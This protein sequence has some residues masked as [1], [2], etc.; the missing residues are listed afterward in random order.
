[1]TL[2]NK[3][4]KIPIKKHFYGDYRIEYDGKYVTLFGK[5][6]NYKSMFGDCYEEMVLIPVVAEIR[7]ATPEIIN[8]DNDFIPCAIT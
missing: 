2:Q 3:I 7:N 5:D 1:M 6:T 8:F 4:I